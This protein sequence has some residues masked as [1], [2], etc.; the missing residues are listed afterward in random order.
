MADIHEFEPV[1]PNWI[2]DAKLGQGSY[3]T[4]YKAHRYDQYVT[5]VT[6]TAAIK[7]ISIPDESRNQDTDGFSTETL[8]KYYESQ[9]AQLVKEIES[10]IQLRGKPHIV[11]YEEHRIIPKKG[12]PGYDLFLRME[13]L[14]SLT[15]YV[16]THGPLTRDEIVILGIHMAKALEA[17][18]A[19][20]YIHRDIKPDN[21]FVDCEESGSVSYKLGDFGTARAMENSKNDMTHTG[22]PNYMAPEVYRGL[23]QY[24]QTVDIY[25]LGIVLYKYA[26]HNFLPF[27][28]ESQVNTQDALLKRISGTPLPKPSG[29]DDELA[30]VILHACEATPGK[31]YQ[32]ATEMRIALEKL[33][34]HLPQH[35]V[36]ITCIDQN[37]QQTLKSF[38]TVCSLGE[39]TITAP[40]IDNYILISDKY[41]KITIKESTPL[42]SSI[43]LYYSLDTDRTM[44]MVKVPIICQDENGTELKRYNAKVD[45]GKPNTIKAPMLDGYKVIGET[46]V[47]VQ[48]NP[49]S[50][51]SPNI[52]VFHMEKVEQSISIPIVGKT[53]NGK[54]I[55]QSVLSTNRNS[56]NAIAAPVIKGYLPSDK[57]PIFLDLR[58]DSKIPEQITIHYQKKNK[59]WFVIGLFALVICGIACLLL[60]GLIHQQPSADVIVSPVISEPTILP[61]DITDEIEQIVEPS[62]IT[63]DL[64]AKQNVNPVATIAST[65]H[66][67]PTPA[68][69]VMPTSTASP[70]PTPDITS[71]PSPTFIPFAET[72]TPVP[73][74]PESP[75]TPTETPYINA[76][77]SVINSSN[78]E[79]SNSEASTQSEV[80]EVSEDSTSLI[81]SFIT[82]GTFE[83]DEKASNGKEPIYWQILD[84][85]DNK[86]LV[87]THK[88]LISRPY[89]TVLQ[90]I[91]WENSEIREWLNSSFYVDA[92]TDE[93]KALIELT[94][95]DNSEAE[96]FPW[97]STTGGNDTE[98]YVFLLSY[99]EA[100][101]QYF[102]DKKSRLILPTK[103]AIE[104]GAYVDYDGYCRWWLRSPA[105]YQECTVAVQSDGSLCDMATVNCAE[106]IVRPALWVDLSKFNGSYISDI[107][108]IDTKIRQAASDYVEFGSFRQ[109][110]DYADPIEWIILEMQNDKCL[111]VSRYGLDT[112][113]FANS[114]LEINTWEN[115]GIRSWLNTYFYDT[116]FSI[117]E[118]N[119]ILLVENTTP[120]VDWQEV[121]QKDGF[122]LNPGS[123]TTI[124]TNN[125]WD[126]IFLLSSQEIDRYMSED[127]SLLYCQATTHAVINKCRLGENGYRSADWWLRSAGAVASMATFIVNDNGRRSCAQVSEQDL[128]VRPAIWLNLANNQTLANSVHTV[129]NNNHPEDTQSI[130]PNTQSNI[131]FKMPAILNREIDY[132]AYFQD[133][134]IDKK[135]I[136]WSVIAQSDNTVLLLSDYCLDVRPFSK[137]NSVR[138]KNNWAKSDLRKWLNE[139]FYNA[140][141][142]QEEQERII[143]VKYT[144]DGEMLTDKV[145][146][147]S[148]DEIE[149]LNV[150]WACGY[151]DYAGSKGAILDNDDHCHGWTRSGTWYD[152]QQPISETQGCVRPCIW[153]D[154]SDNCSPSTT[155]IDQESALSI[156]ADYSNQNMTTGYCQHHYVEISRFDKCDYEIITYQCDKCQDIFTESELKN[157]CNDLSNH[158]LP[159]QPNS[160]EMVDG[161]LREWYFCEV[162]GDGFGIDVY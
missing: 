94:D 151:T 122:T 88:G 91:T 6:Q 86:A 142:S 2:V 96:C 25:S 27:V 11:S 97:Y 89:N 60:P 50:S 20:K 124:E 158:T 28:S 78:I 55:Y 3:G 136:S 132:G 51:C 17:L 77:D 31:R 83:Q 156:P 95:V 4:V 61:S 40:V 10:M 155:E 115:S 112:H 85:Q 130:T 44:C 59:P 139:I 101:T 120:P 63:T 126:S 84:V 110:N 161:H 34:Q 121:A 127:D 7:H 23:A 133:S 76:I 116:A 79:A 39:N 41:T 38:D 16:E 129:W 81:G 90:D 57:E 71:T 47:N 24:D 35:T 102:P 33:L 162:C 46:S 19:K 73:V 128:V 42:S 22:T 48:V 117:E 26:N 80:I 107:T 149:R 87:I 114:G 66:V 119:S 138:N 75:I 43:T 123:Y 125:T 5:G 141:F 92:F 37:N 118:R 82:L 14:T 8:Y 146:L 98:D 54:I 150:H 131:N 104:N 137:A 103:S 18:Q 143:N 64:S 62:N 148:N 58:D 111:L 153:V 1:W 69:T 53:R 68:N 65:N 99:H 140:A 108:D 113:N 32:N 93:E 144:V 109:E 106:F 30:S 160:T 159:E 21:I 145:F 134:Y 67:S 36:K 135:S 157:K 100:M 12:R 154:I 45:Y 15:K 56:K 72:S 49:D 152:F 147:L 105:Q 29:V 74:N 9:L 70:T 52:V 13:L